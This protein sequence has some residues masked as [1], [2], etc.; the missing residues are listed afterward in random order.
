MNNR[1]MPF[2]FLIYF[3]LELFTCIHKFKWLLCIKRLIHVLSFEY[4]NELNSHNKYT[5]MAME[6]ALSVHHHHTKNSLAHHT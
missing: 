5:N 2:C 6:T 3:I 4:I 1:K